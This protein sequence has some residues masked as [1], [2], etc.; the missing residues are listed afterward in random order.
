MGTGQQLHG[1]C[2]HTSYSHLRPE[3]QGSA[4]ASFGCSGL[5][6]DVVI[7]RLQTLHADVNSMYA[8][9]ALLRPSPG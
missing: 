9:C 4:A 5:L 2:H 1:Q 6:S 7:A 3:Q 8:H